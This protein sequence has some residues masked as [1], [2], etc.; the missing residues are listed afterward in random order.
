MSGYNSMNC[1]IPRLVLNCSDK[2]NIYKNK[3]FIP[4]P[5]NANCPP[6]SSDVPLFR[7]IAMNGMPY[8]TPTYKPPYPSCN[9]CKTRNTCTTCKTHT[10]S[11]HTCAK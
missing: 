2:I 6:P 1:T 11:C 8:P 10:T 5:T 3:C 4:L 9:T 7:P